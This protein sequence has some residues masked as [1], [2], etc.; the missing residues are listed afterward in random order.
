MA[1][2]KRTLRSMSPT[3][4]KLARLIGEQ[5][6]I[7]RR[8]KSLMPE[9]GEQEFKSLALKTAKQGSPDQIKREPITELFAIPPKGR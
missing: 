6:S 9:I 3:T 8:L 4:R 5:E 7:A 1:Y 2:R